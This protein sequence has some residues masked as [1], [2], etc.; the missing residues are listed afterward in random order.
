MEVCCFDLK[1]NRHYFVNYYFSSIDYDFE[2]SRF[3]GTADIV[4]F[5]RESI[6]YRNIHIDLWSSNLCFVFLFCLVINNMMN[7]F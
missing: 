5:D 3:W 2:L 4:D 1:K 6:D 7:L